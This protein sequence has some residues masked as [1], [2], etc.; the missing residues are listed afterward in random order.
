MSKG[1]F[2]S[3]SNKMQHLNIIKS[4][5]WNYNW[6]S[7]LWT[8]GTKIKLYGYVQN[9]HIW[10]NKGTEYKEKHLLTYRY[11]GGSL[12]L[13]GCFAARGTPGALVKINGI[14][15]SAKYTCLKSG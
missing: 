14:M 6:N 11:G 4:D 13:C 15:N 5:C 12:K 9:V 7:V 2:L 10:W 1:N 8:Y 3:T